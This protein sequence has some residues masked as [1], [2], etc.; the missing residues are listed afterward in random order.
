MGLVTACTERS[1]GDGAD[2]GPSIFDIDA[3]TVVVDAGSDAALDAPVPREPVVFIASGAPSDAPD[4]FGGD[5]RTAQLPVV[6]YPV[7]GT[8]LPPNLSGLEIHWEPNGHTLFELRFDQGED[9]VLQVYAPCTVRGE[10]CALELG[11]LMWE[12]LADDRARGTYEVQ[13][14]G[15]GAEGTNI[16]ESEPITIELATEPVTGGL[17][18]WSTDPAAIHRYDFDRGHRTSELFFDSGDSG[19]HCVGCHALSRDGETIAIGY[20]TTGPIA[21]IDVATRAESRQ[22]AAEMSSFSPDGTELVT[23]GIPGSD[24]RPLQIVRVDGTGEPLVLGEGAAPDWS[25]DGRAIVFTDP[26]EALRITERDDAGVWTTRTAPLARTGA[27]DEFGSFA[28]DSEWIAFS[29]VTPS[30][31]PGGIESHVY[32]VRRDGDAIEQQLVR[33]SSGSLDSMP[34][35]NPSIFLHHGRRLFWVTFT[36][37]MPFGVE[38][39]DRRRTIWMAAFDPGAEDG[40]PSFPAFRLPFQPTTGSNFI[41]QWTTRV[42]RMPCDDDGDCRR[43]EMCTGG[44]CVPEII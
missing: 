39:G 37:N 22:L 33:V 15:I 29:R 32:V 23:G 21:L 4:R 14:R 9:T 42:E 30:H 17:Y 26:A 2:S 25:P 1:P 44:I 31:L 38:P 24:V 5:G 18:F 28:P 40:D 35:W 19:G 27:R 41:P 10:G 13:V 20:G 36:S 34:R 8:M 16:G 11:D 12:V 7:D 6:R 43:G 3:N